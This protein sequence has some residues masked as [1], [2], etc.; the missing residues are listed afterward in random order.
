MKLLE[1]YLKG[2]NEQV[3]QNPKLQEEIVKF[4]NKN[5]YPYDKQIH[6]L[7]DEL[8][9]EPDVL[10]SQVYYLLTDLL[11]GVGKHNDVPD[12]EFDPKELDAGIKVEHEHTDNDTIAKSISKDHLSEFKDYYSRLSKMEHEAEEYWKDKK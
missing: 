8:K 11:K 7:A 1:N 10:E 3:S 12:S 6:Q 4:I 5:P 9:I 2:L